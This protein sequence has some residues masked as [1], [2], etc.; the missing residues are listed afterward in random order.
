MNAYLG[1]DQHKA[2]ENPYIKQPH[3]NKNK[4]VRP[5]P[6]LAHSKHQKKKFSS[7]F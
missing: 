7:F 4:Y 6:K 5:R 3:Y 2:L 1:H